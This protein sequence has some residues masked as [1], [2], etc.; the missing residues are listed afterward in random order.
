VF[1]TSP[2][3]QSADRLKKLV[4]DLSGI[5]HSGRKLRL[6][7]FD[8]DAKSF[9]KILGAQKLIYEGMIGGHAR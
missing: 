8:F 6:K 7:I 3:N 5:L 1:T 4:A 2:T 9:P